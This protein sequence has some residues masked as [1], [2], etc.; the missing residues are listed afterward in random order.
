MTLGE[1]ETTQESF[2]KYVPALPGVS[3]LDPVYTAIL[4]SGI[5]PGSM[6]P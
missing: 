4:I 1:L 2:K 5:L 6:E 3:S